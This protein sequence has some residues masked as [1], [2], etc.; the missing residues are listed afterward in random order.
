MIDRRAQQKAMLAD[1]VRFAQE[2]IF[3]TKLT[4]EEKQY[5]LLDRSI[6]TGLGNASTS[7]GVTTFERDDRNESSNSGEGHSQFWGG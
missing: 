4:P 6:G 3:W 2:G 5:Y 1:S 7:P